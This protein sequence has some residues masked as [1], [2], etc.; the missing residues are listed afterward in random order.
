MDF[1]NVKYKKDIDG[2]VSY[3]NELFKSKFGNVFDVIERLRSELKEHKQISDSDL[4]YILVDF[5]IELIHVSEELNN[6]RLS[7]EVAK[8]KHKDIV[9]QV[10]SKYI[11]WYGE[12]PRSAPCSAKDFINNDSSVIE[13]LIYQTILNNMITRI[14]NC[15][16]YSRELI[17]GAKK[18][19][20]SRRASENVMP[21]GEMNLDN[22]PEY[23]TPNKQ[24]YIK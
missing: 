2:V 9:N 16:S 14:E 8:M 20:D 6:F 1:D 17:M 10:T 23:P 21:I 24:Q 19:W 4:Q 22:I 5:P 18:I 12:N 15:M 3:A 13:S 7:V 11:N